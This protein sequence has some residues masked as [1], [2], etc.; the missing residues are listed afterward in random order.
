MMN[1]TSQM[2]A[3]PKPKKI[4]NQMKLKSN[5]LPKSKKSK[6]GIEIFTNAL[7]NAENPKLVEEEKK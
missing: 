2:K 4:L 1:K 3:K 6:E 5:H 7:K